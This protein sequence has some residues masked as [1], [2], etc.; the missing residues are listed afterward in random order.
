MKKFMKNI[1][2]R[3]A[4]TYTIMMVCFAIITRSRGIETIQVVRLAEL[5]LLS[6]IGGG[7]MEFSFGTCMIRKMTDAKRSC[8]F[9][10]PFATVTFLF[11]VIFQWITELKKIS[12]YL[13][14]AGMFLVCW[15]ISIVL[16][17]IEHIIRG[18]KYTEKLREYQ[19]GGKHH[20]Q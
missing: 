3:I 2:G 7:W 11:A 14:F 9:I 16:F 17:E 19:T 15:V 20:E 8:I 4:A 1:P 5:F 10:V 6:V 13:K 12:T 18:K